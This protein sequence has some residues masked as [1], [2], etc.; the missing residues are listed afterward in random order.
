M[1]VR[2]A[3]AVYVL[4]V[5]VPAARLAEALR[6]VRPEAGWFSVVID[7]NNRIVV[8]SVDHDKFV[9]KTAQVELINAA[10]SGQGVWRIGTADRAEISSSSIRS[11]R[12]GW[13]VVVTVPNEVLGAPV[14]NAIWS[15]L[16]ASLILLVVALALTYWA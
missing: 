13:T 3:D 10:K 1:P 4:S 7:N 14:K 5:D 6:E 8:G 2:T 11:T 12:T 16:A 9:G 15:V